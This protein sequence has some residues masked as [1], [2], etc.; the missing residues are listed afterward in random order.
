MKRFGESILYRVPVSFL[1]RV[2]FFLF[3]HDFIGA[4]IRFA[5]FKK[6][7]K[8]IPPFSRVLDAGCGTGDFSFFIAERYP[9]STFYA[10]DINKK[11]LQ[12][13]TELQK[14]MGISNISF[15]N[16]NILTLDEQNVYDCIFSIGTLIYF[17]KQDTKNIL[18]RLTSALQNNGYLYL[19]LP[20]KDFLEVRWFPTTWYPTYYTAQKQ[21]NSGDLYTFDEMQMLLQEIGYTILLANKS[22]SYPGKLAWELDNVLRERK[23]NKLRYFFLPFFKILAYIDAITKHKKGCCFV[24]LARKR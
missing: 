14:K 8:K 2:R 16:K 1:Q 21:E 13:N 20:Q 7:L 4:A 11:T 3:G 12:Q 23:S 19:D 6:I 18:L 22:F 5:H 17:S 24:I 9:N 10:Y 15:S